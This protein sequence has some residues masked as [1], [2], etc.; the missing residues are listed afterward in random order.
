[1][2]FS[3]LSQMDAL[4]DQFEVKRLLEMGV[5]IQST[6]D[7]DSSNFGSSLTGKF[8]RTFRKK[9]RNGQLCWYRRSLDW[10]PGSTI[11]FLSGRIHSPQLPTQWSRD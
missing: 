9:E 11:T 4:A 1:M 8:V 6:G 3:L 5:L 10:W 2:E 7:E